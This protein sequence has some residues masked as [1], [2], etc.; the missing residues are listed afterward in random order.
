MSPTR[1]ARDAILTHRLVPVI[2]HLEGLSA[3]SMAFTT[4]EVSSGAIEL[5]MT[6]PGVFDLATQLRS[7]FPTAAIGLGTVTSAGEVDSAVAAGIDFIVSP[8]FSEALVEACTSHGV[9]YIP[10][11]LTPT[12]VRTAIEFD[13][14][15]VKL[16]PAST[17][18]ASHL[19][20]LKE[21]F[22]GMD[23]MPTGG[24]SLATLRDWLDAGS[25]A[26]GVAGALSRSYDIGGDDAL[27]NVLNQYLAVSNKEK[28][29]ASN[30]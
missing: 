7:E 12:E 3:R 14:A 2:R 30:G 6:I 5:T 21:V 27:R 22:P 29:E 26:F 4:L 10:G 20:A 28:E 18:G 11:I 13:C 24:V 1:T 19:N 9:L 23:F 15:L 8:G 25:A 16:F 17:V